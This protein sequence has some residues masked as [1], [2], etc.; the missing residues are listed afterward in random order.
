MLRFL[1]LALFLP[2][3][4]F[5]GERELYAIF[6]L[7]PGA[8]RLAVQEARRQLALKLHPDRNGGDHL[9]LAKVNAAYDELMDLI[10]PDDV[11]IT[12]PREVVLGQIIA[13][14]VDKLS[15]VDLRDSPQGLAARAS[16]IIQ[17]QSGY[18]ADQKIRASELE[19]LINEFG[20]ARGDQAGRALSYGVIKLL[21]E[22][23]KTQVGASEAL[24]R[25]R[26]SLIVK[27]NERALRE[28]Q[29][30]VELHDFMEG[31][32]DRPCDAAL[33]YR[34]TPPKSTKGTFDR[35]I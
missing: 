33:R 29:L 18:F 34:S 21:S 28:A 5:G 27:S 19:R 16:A 24:S 25:I 26:E 35:S 15:V 32:A 17:F 30:F 6:G 14:F 9:P 22:M 11:V 7:A 1:L 2:G 23:A 10:A 31:A 3:P 12:R 13:D 8:S 4:A 20:I